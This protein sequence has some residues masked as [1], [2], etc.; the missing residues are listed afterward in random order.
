MHIK[1]CLKGH[2]GTLEDVI[3]LAEMSIVGTVM[4][5]C[6]VQNVLIFLN[7]HLRHSCTHTC[8]RTALVYVH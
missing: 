4:Q 2:V 3:I 6:F 8:H 5:L 7:E 1:L